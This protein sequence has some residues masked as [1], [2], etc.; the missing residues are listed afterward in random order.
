MLTLKDRENGRD[1]F[2]TCSFATTGIIYG[3]VFIVLVSFLGILWGMVA[4]I[5]IFFVVVVPT[6]QAIADLFADYQPDSECPV[7]S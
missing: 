1:F 2:R 7:S 4:G 3:A 6:V 5:L